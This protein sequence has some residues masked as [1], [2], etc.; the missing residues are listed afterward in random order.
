MWFYFYGEGLGWV[1]VGQSLYPYMYDG[2]KG[3]V[4]HL[5]GSDLFSDLETGDWF[6]VGE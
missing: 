4:M 5:E 3:W 1:W 2:E 6:Q